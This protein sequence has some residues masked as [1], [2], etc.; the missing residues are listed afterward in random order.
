[1]AVQVL[2]RPAFQ[3]I[4]GANG[5]MA[6]A[7]R[8]IGRSFAAVG[9]R[10]RGATCARSRWSL[11]LDSPRSTVL[12]DRPDEL[13]SV[14]SPGRSRWEAGGRIDR[15]RWVRR[16]RAE[17]GRLPGGVPRWCSRFSCSELEAVRRL[18]ARCGELAARCPGTPS[19]QSTP[20]RDGTTPRRD[21]FV[22]VPGRGAVVHGA[23]EAAAPPASE[24]D[25]AVRAIRFGRRAR[26][27]R[28][29]GGA[30]AGSLSSARTI[31]RAPMPPR[32]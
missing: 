12:R 23:G 21:A 32:A 16:R 27:R 22:H 17:R 29:R 1:M 9:W 13:R 15:N 3:E 26:T 11:E 2:R 28:A 24:R 25:A 8:R 18:C 7:K 19:Q 10:S 4:V 31:S 6:L 5:L 14:S 20:P 30:A